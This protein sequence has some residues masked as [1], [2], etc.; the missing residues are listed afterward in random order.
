MIHSAFGALESALDHSL[1][2][3]R[4]E[5]RYLRLVTTL[6]HALDYGAGGFHVSV[7][8]GLCGGSGDPSHDF[9]QGGTKPG[10]CTMPLNDANI[11]A[12][13]DTSARRYQEAYL[14]AQSGAS[15][16]EVKARLAYANEAAN[17]AYGM[18]GVEPP[19]DPVTALPDPV[20]VHPQMRTWKVAAASAGLLGGLGLALWYLDK[21]QP[22]GIGR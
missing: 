3:F 7:T 9:T 22:R 17:I 13:W 21:K 4:G 10:A 19:R 8:R 16:A 20:G 12:A 18:E 2:P 15:V 11:A 14:S 5:P 1:V 6:A